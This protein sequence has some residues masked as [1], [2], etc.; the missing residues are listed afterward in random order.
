M[1]SL[2]LVVRRSTAGIADQAAPAAAPASPSNTSV[3][4]LR[5]AP[6]E[7]ER[8]ADGTDRAHHHLALAADVEQAGPGRYHHG[9]CAQQQRGGADQRL[10]DAGRVAERGVPHGPERLDGVG[11]VDGQE[12]GVDEH[13]PTEGDGPADHAGDRPDVLAA[14]PAGRRRGGGRLGGPLI[15]GSVIDDLFDRGVGYGGHAALL[16]VR[17]LE[18][19]PADLLTVGTVGVDDS[20]DVTVVQDDDPIGDHHQ[21]VEIFGHHQHADARGAPFEQQLL[22]LAHRGDVETTTRIGDDEQR[23]TVGRE[24]PGEHHPLHVAAGQRVDPAV[25][26]GHRQSPADGIVRVRRGAPPAQSTPRPRRGNGRPSSTR[27]WSTVRP[28]TTASPTGSSGTSIAPARRADVG[29]AATHVLAGDVDLP[30]DDG[31]QAEHRFEQFRLTVA[32]H[33]RHTEDLARPDLEHGVVHG[34]AT[35]GAAHRDTVDHE[36][37]LRADGLAFGRQRGHALADHPLDQFLV[38]HRRGVVAADHHLSAAQHGHPVGDRP[39][40][41]QL[42]RD[43]HDRESVLAEAVDHAEQCLD[44]L[45]SERTRGLVEDDDARLGDQHPDELDDLALREAQVAHQRVGIDVEA[46]AL[47]RL[48]DPFPR[49]RRDACGRCRSTVRCSRAR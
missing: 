27:C 4:S 13:G 29:P 6:V 12:G 20:G 30:F 49:R 26:A 39:G 44:L 18:H 28:G 22:G 11:A 40:L 1:A 2:A 14:P 19:Q 33:S 31:P 38:G 5:Q 21:L 43:D 17:S 37:G 42:V 15:C 16:I 48:D 32:R 3:S 36:R 25:E 41:A 8:H 34:E 23:D 45:R 47:G 9:Q 7:R 46:E 24:R 10:A 35:V